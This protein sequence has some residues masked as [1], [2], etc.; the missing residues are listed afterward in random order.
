[1]RGSWVRVPPPA[2]GIIVCM[3]LGHRHPISILISEINTIF[4][5]MGFSIAEGPEIESEWYNFDALNVPADHPSRDMQDTF[6]IKGRDKTV[7]RTHT[8]PVQVRYLE[9]HKDK[10]PIRIIVPG[11]VYRNEATDATPEAQFYQVEGLMVGEGVTL[12]N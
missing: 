7:L 2:Q 1:M 4:S 5:K 12:A 8:S 3:S 6:F 11:K 10:L 9:A